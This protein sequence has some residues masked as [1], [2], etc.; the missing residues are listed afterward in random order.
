MHTDLVVIGAGVVG[1]ACAAEGARK[2][3][4]TLLIEKHRS[5]GQETSSRNS[6]VIHSGIYYPAGSLKARLCVEANRNIYGECEKQDVWAKKC[7]KLIVAA[8]PEEEEALIKLYERGVANGV[9]GLELLSKSMAEKMEPE[10][11]CVSAIFLPSTGIIDSHELM[12]SYL[13][14]AKENGAETAFGVEF[15]SA[16]RRNGLYNLIM[17]DS[18][19]ETTEVESRYVINSGGLHADKVA[20]GFGLDIDRSGYRLHHNRGHYYQV[21]PSKSRLVSHLVYP[22]PHTQ[23]V[24]IGVHITI[25]RAGQVKLG[26]D[27]EYLD[28]AVPESLWYQ[29]DES[30]KEKFYEA[31]KQYF[32]ALEIEDLSPGQVGV[33][34]KLPGSEETIKDFIIREESGKGLPGVVSLIGIESPGLTCSREIAREVFKIMNN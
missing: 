34:P 6:E 29:F 28:P 25:D 13:F 17:K 12:K 22:L 33:R 11:R 9:E 10:I 23:M 21:S 30:R 5:F 7:G 3:F 20:A 1:L 32:P 16:E 15:V 4:S 24:S 31:A 2:G 18:T 26:P 8:V 27:T 19:G 14:E